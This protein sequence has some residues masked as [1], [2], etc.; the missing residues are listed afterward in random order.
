[1]TEI[2]VLDGML[3]PNTHDDQGRLHGTIELEGGIYGQMISGNHRWVLKVT[4]VHGVQQVPV[5]WLNPYG[6]VERRSTSFYFDDNDERW[7][8]GWTRYYG[9]S[10]FD[11]DE[12]ITHQGFR[13]PSTPREHVAYEEGK[14]VYYVNYRTRHSAVSYG[15]AK[16]PAPDKWPAEWN[17]QPKMRLGSTNT[18]TNGVYKPWTSYNT[19]PG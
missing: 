2:Q 17:P 4:Y 6:K 5:K 8:D 11:C 12:V 1:M 15:E 10:S 19:S 13:G 14:A 7:P 18:K 3:D 9:T 16:P